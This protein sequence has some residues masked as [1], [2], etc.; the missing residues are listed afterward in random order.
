MIIQKRVTKLDSVA[1]TSL[2]RGENIE[3]GVIK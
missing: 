3:S 1:R 2:A